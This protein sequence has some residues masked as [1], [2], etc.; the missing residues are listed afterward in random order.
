MPK[1]T[2]QKD[3]V[4][5]CIVNCGKVLLCYPSI[6]SAGVMGDSRTYD[7]MTAYWGMASIWISWKSISSRL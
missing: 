5:E 7:A 6:K 4:Q 2:Y 1:L 3:D